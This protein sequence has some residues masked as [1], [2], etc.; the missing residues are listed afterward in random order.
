[1]LDNNVHEIP[2][3]IGDFG[4]LVYGGFTKTKALL[5]N[6]ITA[7]IAILG[8]ISGYLLIFII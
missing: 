7:L 3:E 5:L 4:V 2:Q 8:G 1:M 6:F